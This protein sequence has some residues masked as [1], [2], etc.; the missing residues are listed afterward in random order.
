MQMKGEKVSTNGPLSHSLNVWVKKF[1]NS[2]CNLVGIK[3][4]GC[5]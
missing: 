3:L 4:E 5:S 2:F 1:S